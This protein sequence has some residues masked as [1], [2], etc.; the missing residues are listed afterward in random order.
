VRRWRNA[1]SSRAFCLAQGFTR[2]GEFATGAAISLPHRRY[3]SKTIPA[4]LSRV[5]GI[6]IDQAARASGP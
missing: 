1:A 6:V 2:T 3:L 4:C 5:T